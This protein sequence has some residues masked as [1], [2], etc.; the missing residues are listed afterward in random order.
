MNLQ[1][2][3]ITQPQRSRK[4][5][6]KRRSYEFTKIFYRKNNYFNSNSKIKYHKPTEQFY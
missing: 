3:R 1:L 5:E 2:A 4:T 6:L